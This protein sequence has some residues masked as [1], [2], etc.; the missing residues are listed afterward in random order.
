MLEVWIQWTCDGCGETE[1][2][3]L[4]NETKAEVRKMLREGGWR[5]FGKLDYCPKCVKN[6]KAENRDTS[7]G[8]VAEKST[9]E[10]KKSGTKK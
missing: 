1:S 7:M 6:G 9:N 5:C 2:T 4:P 3:P 8:E 10:E